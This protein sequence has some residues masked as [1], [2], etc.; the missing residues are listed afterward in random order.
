MEPRNRTANT[1]CSR[2]SADRE[3]HG[4]CSAQ[5]YGTNENWTGDT[6]TIAFRGAVV[7]CF[8]EW[9]CTPVR[10]E[11]HTI[12]PGSAIIGQISKQEM[13]LTH[14]PLRCRF[15]LPPTLFWSWNSEAG[16]M[17]SNWMGVPGTIRSSGSAALD[18]FWDAPLE[19][20]IPPGLA[21]QREGGK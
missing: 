9:V 1:C 2:E 6:P 16:N 13:V 5:E 20:C 8:S 14:Q 4:I 15:Y 17:M 19:D 12:Q 10:E 7:I 21:L 11:M 3:D 18:V